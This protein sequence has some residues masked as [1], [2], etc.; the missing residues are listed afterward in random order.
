MSEEVVLWLTLSNRFNHI[1]DSRKSGLIVQRNIFRADSKRFDRTLPPCMSSGKQ[2]F[3]ESN[4]PFLPRD[5]NLG[6]FILDQLHSKINSVSNDVLDQ[7]KL[8]TDGESTPQDPDLLRPWTDAKKTGVAAIERELD[9]IEA[10]VKSCKTRWS[11]TGGG[12]ASNF[13]TESHAQRKKKEKQKLVQDLQEKFRQ[14]PDGVV[15]LPLM[16]SGTVDILKA[17]LAY[18]MSETFAF[19]MAFKLLCRIKAESHGMVA[20][21][22]EFSESMSI[23]SSIAR[24]LTMEQEN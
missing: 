7:L 9:L 13:T 18:S 22:R 23:P 2:W 5:S 1:L 17:S 14:K 10:H 16:G 4:R 11:L 12:R 3:G 24:L 21:T 19:S 15:L 6:P 20:V 8:Q